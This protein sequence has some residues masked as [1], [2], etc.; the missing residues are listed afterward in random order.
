MW[1]LSG[2]AGVCVLTCREVTAS[3]FLSSPAPHE[4]GQLAPD[5]IVKHE[6]PVLCL[7]RGVGEPQGA[8]TAWND[9][10]L[11][12]LN[13]QRSMPRVSHHADVKAEGEWPVAHVSKATAAIVTRHQQTAPRLRQQH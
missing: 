12:H 6:G 8:P 11:L 7:G 10:Q 1:Q 13:G 9:A 5:L 3:Q 2:L 4:H